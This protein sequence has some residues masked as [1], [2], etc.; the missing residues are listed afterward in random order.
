MTDKKFDCVEMKLKGAE[1]VQREIQG[2]TPKQELE[3]WKRSTQELKK[4]QSKLK[5]PHKE[6]TTSISSLNF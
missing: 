4:Q 2:M 6:S 5:H 1:V 3:Y